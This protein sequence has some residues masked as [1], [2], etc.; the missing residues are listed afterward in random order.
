MSNRRSSIAN[1]V[2]PHGRGE[3]CPATNNS[4]CCTGSSPRAWG[5]QFRQMLLAR[6][7]RFIP[8]GVGNTD[9]ADGIDPAN[10]VHPHGRGEHLCPRLGGGGCS[11]SSPRA[12]GTLELAL[13]LLVK[14]RFI[15]TGVGNT[16]SSVVSTNT[17]AVHPHGRG[18]HF[19]GF[20][21]KHSAI[22]SSPRAWGTLVYRLFA[23]YKI[24]FIPTGV[25]NTIAFYITHFNPSGSSPRAWGTRVKL[26][27]S[28]IVRRF[29]PTGVG[30][31]LRS[32]LVCI[33]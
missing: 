25:G 9:E 26:S 13:V 17:G 33:A 12:W 5:T 15:P 23:Y 24:R 6:Q 3:H 29:I 14:V 30:N 10:A 1:A 27:D 22:G 11:G 8:T 20:N 18:E 32:G 4:M 21:F 16:S 19:N 31:T 28:Q 2:H 7:A